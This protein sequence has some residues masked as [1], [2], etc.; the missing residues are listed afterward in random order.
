MGQ[1]ATA[2]PRAPPGPPAAREADP[3]V[4]GVAEQGELRIAKIAGHGAHGD[5]LRAVHEGML[6]DH[7][8]VQ[9]GPH[10][11]WQHRGD[12][13]DLHWAPGDPGDLRYRGGEPVV[14][15]IGTV[16]RQRGN[17]FMERAVRRLHRDQH[18]LAVVNHLGERAETQ[19]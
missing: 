19:R 10:R 1:D 4:I 7:G 14:R 11:A 9:P 3:A 18:A 2:T 12:H 8:R 6:T 16:K 5:E 17:A 13:A 15:E